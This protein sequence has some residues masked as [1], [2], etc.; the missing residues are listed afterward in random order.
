MLAGR[1]G[2]VAGVNSLYD[3]RRG[4]ESHNLDNLSLQH[5]AQSQ[6]TP[7]DLNWR[8][9]WVMYDVHCMVLTL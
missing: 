2:E 7:R 4:E 8:V 5:S 6:P 3:D 1:G 9:C